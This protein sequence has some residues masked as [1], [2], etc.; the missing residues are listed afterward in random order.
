MLKVSTTNDYTNLDI[1]TINFQ[2][3]LVHL[4]YD[5]KAGK[6][7]ELENLYREKERLEASISRRKKLLSN[8]NYVKKAP[9]KIVEEEKANLEKEQKE[10]E[11]II[12]KIS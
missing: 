9:E 8:E 12:V 6:T 4:Y 3:D 7:A 10:L 2:D 1:V 5:G 11:V